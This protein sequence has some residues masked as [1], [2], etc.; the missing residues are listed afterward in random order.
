[1]VPLAVLALILM[2]RPEVPVAEI[3]LELN[4]SSHRQATPR[5]EKPSPSP[6]QVSGRPSKWL[7]RAAHV[8][9]GDDSS[10]DFLKG[11]TKPNAI[12]EFGPFLK[13]EKPGTS[14]Y[15][16]AAFALAVN[17]VDIPT[18]LG[19][20]V[21][22]LKTS[23]G[24]IESIEA[25]GGLNKDEI[26]PEDIPTSVYT[27]YKLRH[28]A[29]ALHLLFTT[30]IEGAVA[31]N[32]DDDVMDAMTYHAVDVIRLATS[33]PVVYAK[34]WDILDWNIGPMSDRMALI[35][36]LETEK[37]PSDALRK[38]AVRLASDLTRPKHRPGLGI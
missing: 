18:N 23:S 5:G 37:W 7:Q 34:L 24:Q 12:R 30:P 1:M 2:L 17:G 35:R 25:S 22:P 28:N 21:G 31:E 36:R 3:H 4:P 15:L 32:R 14:A 26:L 27:V 19:R 16:V 8:F 29:M 11:L 33:D 9:N 6:D 20:I 10:D 13:S 38:T